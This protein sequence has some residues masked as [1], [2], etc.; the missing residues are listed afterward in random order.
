MKI[1]STLMIALAATF[2]A[3]CQ[4]AGAQPV[5]TTAYGFATPMPGSTVKPKIMGTVLG[6][7]R[8]S[9]PKCTLQSRLSIGR[10]TNATQICSGL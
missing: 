4:T 9:I 2:L 10:I 6:R 1:I 5:F 3:A 7:I 8:S